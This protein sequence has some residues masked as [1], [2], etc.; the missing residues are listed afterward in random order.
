MIIPLTKVN[1]TE[2]TVPAGAKLNASQ[3]DS[4]RKGNL[5]VNFHSAQHKGG[6][7]RAQINPTGGGRSSGY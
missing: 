3:M 5:Y 4:Y 6:E 7:I 1:D 2:W